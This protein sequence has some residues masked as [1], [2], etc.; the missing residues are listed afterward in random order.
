MKQRPQHAVAEPL[1]VIFDLIGRQRNRHHAA[2][3]QGDERGDIF[4]ALSVDQD[5][6]GLRGDR[7]KEDLDAAK[8]A[9]AI[10]APK[11]SRIISNV[12]RPLAAAT[13]PDI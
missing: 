9:E 12:A 2:L 8:F 6:A 10:L 7:L 13:R 5:V 3:L 4:P 11:R 1:V